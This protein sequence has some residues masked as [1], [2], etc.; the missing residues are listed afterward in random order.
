MSDFPLVLVISHSFLSL[1]SCLLLSSVCVF[2]QGRSRRRKKCWR[3]VKAR[4]LQSS[5]DISR[6][7]PRWDFLPSSLP[8]LVLYSFPGRRKASRQRGAD[9]QM[10][11]RA[12][13]VVALQSSSVTLKDGFY[14]PRFRARLEISGG[15]WGSKGTFAGS[16]SLLIK[17]GTIVFP[18]TRGSPPTEQELCFSGTGTK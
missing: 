13:A 10:S 6:G 7:V 5:S 3:A 2:V 12:A 1:R 15:L 4:S 17:P 16:F 14:C 11:A 9:L 18:V 8:C